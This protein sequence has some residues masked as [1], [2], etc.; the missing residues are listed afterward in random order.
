MPEKMNY[1][2]NLMKLLFEA[3]RYQRRHWLVFYICFVSNLVLFVQVRNALLS[4]VRIFFSAVLYSQ[5]YTKEIKVANVV[6]HDI[7]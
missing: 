1:C 4:A 2:V 5:Q 3:S 7:P 6:D